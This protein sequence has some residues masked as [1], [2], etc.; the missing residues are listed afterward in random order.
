MDLETVYYI[1]QTV[2]V[3]VIIATLIALLIQTRQTNSISRAEL[4]QSQWMDWGNMLVSF[5]DTPEKAELLRRGLIEDG[6]LTGAERDRISIFL[7]INVSIA[8][9]AYYL[10]TRGMIEPV[11]YDCNLEMVRF[12]LTFPR[13]R[14]WWQ[15]RGRQFY[16]PPFRDVIDQ[17]VEEAETQQPAESGQG[18]Q[19]G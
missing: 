14:R 12:H 18:V 17:I 4:T 16:K 19:P 5:Y 1:S 11:A 8:E 6:D 13:A 10:K 3:I 2:A 15:K 9:G 7:A